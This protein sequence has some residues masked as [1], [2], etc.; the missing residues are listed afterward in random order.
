MIGREDIEK[1]ASLAR[2]KLSPEE[3]DSLVKEVDPILAYV[4]QI[5]NAP[6]IPQE[7]PTAP[8]ANTIRED[9]NPHE[10]GIHSVD[11]IEAAP[12]KEGKYIKVKK[13]L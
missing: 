12:Q 9:E 1:L 11:L 4:G 6:N 8:T 7:L 13:I 10:S 2:I 5:N 3:L